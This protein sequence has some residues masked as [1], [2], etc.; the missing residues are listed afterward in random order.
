MRL[1]CLVI[2]I[3]FLL[4]VTEASG[5][6]K[7]QSSEYSFDFSLDYVQES[8]EDNKKHEVQ[9]NLQQSNDK[10]VVTICEYDHNEDYYCYDLP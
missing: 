9:P 5:C 6:V 8:N 7:D 1:T 2:F 4:L 10:L 3:L